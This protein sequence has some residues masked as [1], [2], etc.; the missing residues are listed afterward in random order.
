MLLTELA[1]KRVRLAA[2]VVV[3]LLV[4]HCNTSKGSR[5]E[6]TQQTD[7]QVR[8]Q[9]RRSLTFCAKGRSRQ[10][11]P[12]AREA[13]ARVVMTIGDRER[14]AGEGRVDISA[15]DWAEAQVAAVRD[16]PEARLALLV[17]TYHGPTGRAPRHLP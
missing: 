10:S 15:L 3:P 5:L 12:L 8:P 11:F 6:W 17:R 9:P 2:N 1:E 14:V 4:I 13:V 7:E 16:E